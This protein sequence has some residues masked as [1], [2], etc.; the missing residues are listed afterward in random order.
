[1]N[2]K[3][4][5]DLLEDVWPMWMGIKYSEGHAAF[6]S[7]IGLRDNPYPPLS[8]NGFLWDFGWVEAEAGR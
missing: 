4:P 1:M 3:S 2:A 6:H 5:R 8:E 7:G